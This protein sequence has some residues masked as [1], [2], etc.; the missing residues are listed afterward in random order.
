MSTFSSSPPWVAKLRP[1]SR[2]LLSFLTYL[3]RIFF[4]S[5]SAFVLWVIQLIRLVL[6]YRGWF[7]YMYRTK[8]ILFIFS[9]LAGFERPFFFPHS[10]FANIGG[11]RFKFWSR[12]SPLEVFFSPPSA[13]M[14]IYSEVFLFF[15]S[16]SG[17]SSMLII[18]MLFFSECAIYPPFPVYALLII[19]LIHLRWRL[20]EHA[21]FWVFS[22]LGVR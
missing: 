13:L 16:S 5:G 12:A 18:V 11:Y 1:N 19:G 8:P 10:A 2:T 4:S 7:K 9:S 17:R 21:Y 22:I 15:P 3:S 14:R 20:E 6:V